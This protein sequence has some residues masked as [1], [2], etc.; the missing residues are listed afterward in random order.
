MFRVEEYA[1]QN[2][3]KKQLCVFFYLEDGGDI[4]LGDAILSHVIRLQLCMT[5]D[6]IRSEARTYARMF[7]IQKLLHIMQNT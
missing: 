5:C 2:I 1:K 6:L 4:F 7:K 3:M